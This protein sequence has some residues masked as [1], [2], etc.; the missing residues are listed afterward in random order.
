MA[1][2]LNMLSKTKPKLTNMKRIL[3]IGL[4]FLFSMQVMAQ[5][6]GVL[7]PCVIQGNDTI[8]VYIMREVKYEQFVDAHMQQKQQQW[9]K[10]MR[11]I[12]IVMPYAKMCSAKLSEMDQTMATLPSEKARRQYLKDE[13]NKMRTQFE[14]KLKDLNFRQGKLLVKLIDRETGRTSYSLIKNYKNG[15]TAFFWQG[16][17]SMFGMSL[18]EEYVAEKE[19]QI[20]LALYVLGYN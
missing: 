20:E 18:K 19:P 11:D 15:I 12:R 2:K 7:A 13:E 4:S 17:A 5:S 9:A 3:I 6:G 8:P 1:Y 14:G 10:L 16:L